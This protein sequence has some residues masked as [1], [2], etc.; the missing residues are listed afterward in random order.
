MLR[1]LT[2]WANINSGSHN[3]EGLARFTSAVEAQFA[4]LG[5]SLH[6]H[7]LPPMETIDSKGNVVRSEL[8]KAIRLVKRPDAPVRVLLGI[9]LDTVYSAQSPFQQTT[10]LNDTT[11]RGPGVTDAKGGLV[12]LLT[13]LRALEQ[14]DLANQIGWEVLLNPDE[15]IGSPGSAQLWLDAAKRNHAALLFEPALPDG[16]LVGAR[17]GSGNFTIIVHGRSAHV[18]RDY[19]NGRSAILALAEFITRFDA[20]QRELSDVTIN[21]GRIEGGGPLNAVADLAIGRFN[22]RI[23]TPADQQEI[24][25]RIS[26]MAD[27]FNCREGIKISVHGQVHAPPKPLDDRSMKLF[28]LAQAC[29]QEL[30]FKL[31]IRPTGGACDGN[32][33]AAAGLPVIDSLGPYGGSIHSDQEFVLIPSLNERAKL[34]AMLLLRIA[35]R[36]PVF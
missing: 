23:T 25:K 16:A 1:L 33:L 2:D 17:K 26:A 7:D 5:A 20:V 13:A 24:E 18:G 21:C 6:R 15:E 9:H 35:E 14:I 19:A 11:L 10:R 31:D 34:T 4:P 29:G 32:R 28:S 8:G 22:V 27:E 12:V 30:G 3:L 36:R